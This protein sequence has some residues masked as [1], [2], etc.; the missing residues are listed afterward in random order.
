MLREDQ[1]SDAGR[2]C[3]PVRFWQ[4]KRGGDHPRRSLPEIGPGIEPLSN[5]QQGRC[6]PGAVLTSRQA[7]P[8]SQLCR[9]TKSLMLTWMQAS[10]DQP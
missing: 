7:R 4:P 6:L 3:Q 10:Q 1:R 8:G 9:R 2:G 5:D